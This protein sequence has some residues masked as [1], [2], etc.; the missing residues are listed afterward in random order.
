[1]APLLPPGYAYGRQWRRS[2]VPGPAFA[3]G[4]TNVRQDVS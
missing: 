4:V 2:A 3:I 1:M